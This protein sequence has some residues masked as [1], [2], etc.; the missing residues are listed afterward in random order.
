MNRREVFP[1]LASSG[2]TRRAG[3]VTRLLLPFLMLLGMLATV[4][5]SPAAVAQDGD[6]IPENVLA[7]SVRIS[8]TLL[9]TPDDED[10][11]PFLCELNDGE[12]LEWSVG[13]GTIITPDGYV[14][15][16]HHVTDNGR[17]PRIARDYCEDQAPGGDAEVTFTQIGWLPDERGIP[18]TAYWTELIQDSSLEEDLAIIQL[19]EHLDGPEI[20]GYFP[21]VEF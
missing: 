2:A 10:D 16:N 15:T 7:A 11:E 17:V 3:T 12:V 6:T 21:V 5:P 8:T 19:T 4:L 13:S 20:D 18:E 9:V 1:D 14:L